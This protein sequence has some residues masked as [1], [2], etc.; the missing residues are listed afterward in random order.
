MRTQNL[1]LEQKEEKYPIPQHTPVQLYKSGIYGGIHFTSRTCF[2]Q[3]DVHNQMGKQEQ[4]ICIC[5]VFK[6]Q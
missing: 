2:P 4:S 5:L 6:C 3:A 1:I